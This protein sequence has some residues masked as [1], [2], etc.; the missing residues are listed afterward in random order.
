MM[1]ASPAQIESRVFDLWAQV[2][3]AQANPLLMLEERK[4]TPLLPL[5]NGGK[6]LDVGCGTGRW[7]AH[8]EELNPA[9]LMGVDCSSAMVDR[10]REKV[11]PTTKVEHGNCSTLPCESSSYTFVMASFLVSYLTDLQLFAR[12]CARVLRPG[13]W[14]L[15]SDMHPET[16]AERGW[17]RSFHVNGARVDIAVHSRSLTEIVATFEQNGFEVRVLIEPAFEEPERLVFEDAGKLGEYEKLAGIPAIY[18]LKLQRQRPLVPMQFPTQATALQLTNARIA[19]G[20]LSWRDGTLLTED[21]RVAAIRNT[22]DAAVQVLNLQDYMLLPGLINSHDHLEFGLF[23]KLGRPAG[24]P[25]YRNATEWAEEIHKIHSRTIERYRQISRTTRLWWG[26]IRNLLCG[27]TT[28]CHHNPLHE[29]MTSPNFPVRVLSRFSWSHSMAFDPDLAKKFRRAPKELPFI[30]HAAEGID[31]ESKS[32]PSRL[33]QMRVLDERSVLVHGLA[34][35]LKEISLINRRGASLVVCPTSNCFLFAKTLSRDLLTSVERVALGSDSPITAAGDL[36]DE[37]RYLSAEVRLNPE[38]IYNMV[39]SSPAEMFRLKDGEGRITESGVADLIA[40]RAR[41]DT[42][43]HAVSG[44]TFSDVK[45]VI[46]AGQV[47]MASPHLFARLPYGLRSGMELIEVA[48]HYRW[49]RLPLRTLFE[50]TEDILEQKTMLLAGREVR[51][52]G[53]L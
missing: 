31:E 9:S 11:L 2:Y 29:E 18:I 10:A 4:A 52:L 30:L 40:V 34:C 27:V 22:A 53:T 26:A 35:D 14:L 39:T 45:L 24:A 16:A 13:R 43:A 42:P 50:A 51:Y 44:L 33:D 8:L 6:V 19:V 38:M 17:T 46:L 23:P 37:V 21:G 48:G 20:P 47:Q 32:E 28:V 15:I 49:I 1:T 41:Y 36:L 25:S 7:L 3:D 12:E 5:V